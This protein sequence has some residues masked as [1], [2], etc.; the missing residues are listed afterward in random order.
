MQIGLLACDQVNPEWRP[1]HGDY[2]DMYQK[3]LAEYEVVPYRIYAG[4][5]PA[6][7][8]I[9]QVWM[10]TGSRYSA[11]DDMEWITWLKKFILSIRDTKSLFIGVCFGHQILGEA[12]GGKLEKSTLGWQVGV[13]D[14]NIL[15]QQSWMTPFQSSINILMMCQ[16]QV[17]KLPP[18]STLLASHPNCPNA[19]FTTE[20]QYLGIQGHP[21]FT[22]AYTKTLMLKREQRIGLERVK[23]GLDSLYNIPDNQLLSS[24]IGNF[25][26][27]GIE[28]L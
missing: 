4:E 1:T 5:Y 20:N 12:L 18:Y 6:D 11:Y 15:Q 14:F 2:P 23:A 28:T 24:W 7:P 3:W 27:T 17:T 21:E 13:L 16:D 10:A 22:K 26:K 9:H 8:T 19:M 25:I